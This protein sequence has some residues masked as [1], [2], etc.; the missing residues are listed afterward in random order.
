M[1][2]YVNYIWVSVIP[3]LGSGQRALGLENHGVIHFLHHTVFYLLTITVSQLKVVCVALH[4]W[5]RG[6][7]A[8]FSI[9]EQ[10]SPPGAVSDLLDCLLLDMNFLHW[11]KRCCSCFSRLFAYFYCLVVVILGSD[12]WTFESQLISSRICWAATLHAMT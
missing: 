9:A 1:W 3:A 4:H 12:F 10:L 6:S 2:D 5:M 11:L 8:M 7:C